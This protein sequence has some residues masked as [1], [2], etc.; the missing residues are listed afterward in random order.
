[1]TK[2]YLDNLEKDLELIIRDNF[3]PKHIELMN[4]TIREEVLEVIKFAREKLN[5]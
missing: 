5:E 4:I 2:E 3:H 1:M